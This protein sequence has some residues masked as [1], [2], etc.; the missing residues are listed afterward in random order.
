MRQYEV[1]ISADYIIPVEA[2][3]GDEA[4]DKAIEVWGNWPTPGASNVSCE[5]VEASKVQ[6]TT[7]LAP[8]RKEN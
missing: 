5:Y 8:T 4:K 1:F 6:K 3:S 7:R 2:E